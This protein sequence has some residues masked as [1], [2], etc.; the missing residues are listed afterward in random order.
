MTSSLLDRPAA[1]ATPDLLATRRSDRASRLLVVLGIGLPTLLI[2]LLMLGGVRSAARVD[3][4]PFVSFDWQAPQIFVANTPTGGDM[5]AHVLLPQVLRDVLLPS[6]KILGWS[7]AWYAGFPALYFYFPLP[8]LVTVALDVILPYG[9]AFKLVSAAGLVAFPGAVYFLVRALAF[10]RPVAALATVTGSMYLFMESFSIFGGNVKSTMAGEFSFSWSLAFSLVYLGIVVRDTREGRRLSPWAGVFLALTALT[11]IVT[12]VVVV[13]VSLPVLIRRRG[14]RA[15]TA[16]W[17]LGFA[18]AAFW[19]LPLGVRLLQGMSTSMN[20]D[21]VEGLIGEGSSPRIVTTTLPDELVP[22]FVLALIGVV[23]MLMRRDDVAVLLAMTVLPAGAYWWFGA[24][25]ITDLYN[26]RFLPYWFVGIFILAGIT[27]GLALTMAARTMSQRSENLLLFG[28]LGMLIVIATTAVAIHDLPGW[29]SWNYAGYEGKPVYS[30]LDDLM[31][32]IDRLPPGRVMWEANGDMNQ[33]GTPM[34]LM[35]TPYFSDTHPSMEGLF[36]ESSLT[37][38]FHFLNASEVSDRPSN[39]K[40]GLDYQGF[41]LDRAIPHLALFDVRYYVAFTE[42]ATLAAQEN[43][44]YTE[45]ASASPWT[46]FELPESSMIDVARYEPV[47]YDGELSVEDWA[48]EWYDYDDPSDLDRWV[49]VDGPAGWRRVDDVADRL[50]FAERY[51]A[52]GAVV[53]NVVVDDERVSFDTTAVGIPHMVKVSYFPNWVATGAEGPY[54]VSPSVMVVIPTD[55][56]VVLEFANTW[57]ENVGNVLTVAGI[58]A[59]VLWM[60]RH[61]RRQ[62]D[63]LAGTADSGAITA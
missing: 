4:F 55:E 27:I 26:A 45:V 10:S 41:D 63:D 17:M 39:P 24:H 13:V 23:W 59:V 50:D 42:R 40:R 15:L 44:N 47:V 54:R 7:M 12:T 46:V 16:S 58:G 49:A 9:V 28:G 5:G 19:A 34:A 29:V 21:P 3:G 53:S 61:R 56:H 51:D 1:T 43:P 11:H 57:A 18:I 33:Y 6:G 60:V 20:W 62:E 2:L 30:Q 36:F 38:P 32:E 37:T 14:A 25:E 22:A 35:L 48:V 31:S 52:A 8:A